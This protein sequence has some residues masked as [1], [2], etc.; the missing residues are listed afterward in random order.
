MKRGRDLAGERVAAAPFPVEFVGLDGEQL[1]L[2]DDTADS[3]LMTWT[4]CTIPDPVGAVREIARVLRPGGTL[5][6]V[7]HGHSPDERVQKWQDRLNGFQRKAACGCNLNRD[8]PA[9]LKAGGMTVAQLDT[10]YSKGEPK[11]WGWTF[12]GRA[13]VA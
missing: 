11:P 6:F 8:I 1:S 10:Y 12:E 13:T 4:L 3:A 5:H 2:D 7:E 9:L